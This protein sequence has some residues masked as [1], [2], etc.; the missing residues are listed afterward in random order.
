MSQFEESFR[1]LLPT[2]IDKNTITHFG[3]DQLDPGNDI[4][5]FLQTEA[6]KV[7]DK[8]MAS[9][10]FAKVSKTAAK[11]SKIL[12]KGKQIVDTLDPSGDIQ[13]KVIEHGKR[14]T[15][16]KRMSFGKKLLRVH[17][18]V[19][20]F[21]RKAVKHGN[22][23]IKIGK[24]IKRIYD[25]VNGTGGSFISKLA[26]IGFHRGKSF[27][28]HTNPLSSALISALEHSGDLAKGDVKK[29]LEGT[30]IDTAKGLN[31]GV[32]TA[33]SAAQNL[34]HLKKGKV[35]KFA[36]N[37]GLD[38]AKSYIGGDLDAHHKHL[39]NKAM[40]KN[41]SPEDIYHAEMMG[42]IMKPLSAGRRS[43]SGE[44]HLQAISKNL[45][46]HKPSIEHT[47][48]IGAGFSEKEMKKIAKLVKS[49]VIKHVKIHGKSNPGVMK[50][51]EKGLGKN[52]FKKH[53]SKFSVY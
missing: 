50:T 17:H 30:A 35:G 16:N 10:Q 33:I 14:I 8:V 41:A 11:A 32:A 37:V 15:K 6:D 34:K 48:D 5:P 47:L 49:N 26:K 42:H 18:K 27:L 45:G 25:A 1:S 13:N 22:R 40:A 9:D 28:K 51:I 36:K 52:V 3:L 12:N 20:N 46:S 4:A 2:S 31:T 43:S 7:K 53:S 29:F 44:A 23:A 38:T 19:G 21:T 39:T 24:D